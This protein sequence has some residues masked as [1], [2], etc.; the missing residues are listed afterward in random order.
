MDVS[1]YQLDVTL[2]VSHDQDCRFFWYLI[3]IFSILS[4]TICI[5]F[6]P[7][8]LGGFARIRGEGY[9]AGVIPTSPNLGVPGCGWENGIGCWWWSA[10]IKY[11]SF[12]S[13]LQ[14]QSSKKPFSLEALSVYWKELAHTSWYQQH[15][16]LSASRLAD[17]RVVSVAVVEWLGDNEGEYVNDNNWSGW[18]SLG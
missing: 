7:W 2:L 13:Q 5:H 3:S 4:T 12:E 14:T 1:S 15:P 16:I 10:L 18:Y 6:S 17:R 8:G 11:W 9:D